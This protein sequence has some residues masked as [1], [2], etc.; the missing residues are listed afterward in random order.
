MRK[1]LRP[2]FWK[3]C[4]GKQIQ[5]KT[6]KLNKRK[7]TMKT[8]SYEHDIKINEVKFLTEPLYFVP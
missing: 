8:F 3:D 5:L 4:S 2:E 6:L 7:E 1:T